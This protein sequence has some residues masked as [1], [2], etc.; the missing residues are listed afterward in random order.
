MVA[1]G[2]VTH[3]K[4]NGEKARLAYAWLAN[5]DKAPR[6]LDKMYVY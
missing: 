5:S 2:Q 4:N 3:D 1:A 6:S